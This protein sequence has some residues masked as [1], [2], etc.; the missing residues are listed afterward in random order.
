MT[1][2]TPD[3]LV[4]AVEDTLAA[5]G[6]AH[7]ASCA[8]CSREASELAAI[9]SATRDLDVPEPSPLFWDHFSHR[10]R[11]AIATEPAD[12][13]RMPRWLQGHVLAPLG[14]LALLVVALASA[15]SRAPV[16]DGPVETVVS[17]SQAPDEVVVLDAA[18]AVVSDLVGP[19]DFE[20]AQQAGIATTLGS[21]E[22]V[23][24]HLTADEQLELLRLLRQ[25]LRRSGG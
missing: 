16:S 20:S 8:V 12:V 5:P 7:I 14:A 15:V 4:E 19:L 18:W 6:R 22:R 11:E 9:L 23:A 2:L 13:P 24:L 21:A 25:E 17:S 3:E 1:H 10:V